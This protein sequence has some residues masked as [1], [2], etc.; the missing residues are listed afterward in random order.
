MTSEQ[1]FSLSGGLAMAGWI[2][3]AFGPRNLRW[4]KGL[5][6][7]AIPLVLSTVYA[8]YLF[9][10]FSES[11]GGYQ[12]LADVRQL[13]SFD[14]LLLAG[15]I[16]YLAFDL[17]IGCFL[18]D[19]MDKTGI[20]RLLQLPVLYLTLMFGPVGFVLVFW[21]ECSLRFVKRRAFSA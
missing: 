7:C 15:W 9:P 12:S 19:R 4:L 10:H 14:E 6:R 3:L 18:A 8:A 13:F 16:H 17:L 1:V 2:L 20:H 11:G 5:I 21:M